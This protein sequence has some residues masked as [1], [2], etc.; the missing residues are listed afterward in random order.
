MSLATKLRLYNTLVV[1]VLLHGA[2]TWT[3]LQSDEQK[4]E[5]FHMTCQRRILGVR[6][7]DFVQNTVIAERTG[8][9]SLLSSIRR[10]RLAIFGHVR[11]L[12]EV[13]PAHVALKLAVDVRSSRTP[14]DD[15]N[16]TQWRRPSGRPRYTWVQQLEADT[17]LTADDLWNIASDRDAWRALR[18]IA[19]QADQ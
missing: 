5:A 6:W 7:Y 19:G 8:L 9:D 3:L 4:L 18:P 13:T 1:S 16:G 10:R 2:E 14:D 15:G 11:R 17:G 12:S